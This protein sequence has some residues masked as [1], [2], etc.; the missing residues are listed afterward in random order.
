MKKPLPKLDDLELIEVS[1]VRCSIRHE[2]AMQYVLRTK[3][4][5]GVI[6]HVITHWFYCRY[7]SPTDWTPPKSVTEAV[8]QYLV[9]QQRRNS[10]REIQ[11]ND[12]AYELIRRQGQCRN[13]TN[14]N[15]T[16]MKLRT[17]GGKTVSSWFLCDYCSPPNFYLPKTAQEAYERWQQ[18]I[19]GQASTEIVGQYIPS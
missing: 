2:G 17:Q 12:N 13:C 10:K 11:S 16:E 9:K 7:C 18:K 4:Q 1:D 6:T 15:V 5:K 14:N 19:E 3:K 8:Q